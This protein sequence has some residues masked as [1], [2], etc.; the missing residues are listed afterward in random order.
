MAKVKETIFVCSSCGNE[1]SKWSGQCL[2]CG[3]W[4]SIREVKNRTSKIKGS[5]VKKGRQTVETKRVSEVKNRKNYS[6][7]SSNISELDRVLGKGVV[8]GSVVL[9][10]GEPGIGKSTL[11]SQLIGKTGGLYVAG[12]ES[13]GQIKLRFDRLG[14]DGINTDILETNGIDDVLAYFDRVKD[15]PKLVVVDSIQVMVTADVESAA[16]SVSQI[17]ESAFAL[18]QLAKEKNVAIIIVGHVTKEGSIAG[19]KL[20]EHM[21][22]VVLYFEGEKTGEFRILRSI[23][24]RFG[25]TDEVGI[26]KM[27]SK[28]LREVTSDEINLAT[29]KKDK[30]GAIK[31]VV[32]EGSRPMMVEIQALVTESFAPMPK[33]VFSGLDFKRGQLLVAVTQKVLDIPLYKYDV[34]V[35]VTGGVKLSDTGCDLA[36]VGAMW[37][38]YKN[39]IVGAKKVLVGEV[40][41]LGEVVGVRQMEKRNR[42][43]KV[44]GREVWEM[45]SIRELK[46]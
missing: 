35:S 30:V 13:A 14:L 9:F 31:T 24:N 12:E 42:E 26:F 15:V 44:L 21:V 7:F 40:S 6:I 37:S 34:Y 17:R 11:L 36:V 32:M 3:E 29:G 41:L 18:I 23:K 38:S 10:S 2:A 28:G 27:E 22:D 25:P 46:A 16:G 45:K 1:F 39:R 8:P 33:R 20:L 4:N 5:S 19:P 43:S